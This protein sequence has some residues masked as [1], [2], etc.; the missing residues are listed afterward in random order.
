[1]AGAPEAAVA[2]SS[3][4]WLAK[5][6]PSVP[7]VCSAK[8]W[9]VLCGH[10]GGG[11]RCPRGPAECRGCSHCLGLW[12]GG[13]IPEWIP[14]GEGG[15]VG[16]HGPCEVAFVDLKDFPH[17]P[18]LPQLCGALIS[19]PLAFLPPRVATGYRQDRARWSAGPLSG[20]AGGPRRPACGSPG[21][22]CGGAAR[23]SCGLCHQ[24]RGHSLPWGTAL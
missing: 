7:L 13:V 12:R 23:G 3:P 22:R 16:L 20:R 11:G 24:D 4:C 15:G 10:Q 14:G 2:S 1:M 5:G 21:G 19:P 17:G 18:F 9:R 6:G 8:A